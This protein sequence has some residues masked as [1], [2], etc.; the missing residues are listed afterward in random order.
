MSYLYQG[1]AQGLLAV[2]CLLSNNRVIAQIIPDTTL[3]TNSLVTPSGNILRIDQG[4]VLGNNLFHSFQEFSVPTNTEAFFDNATN[5]NNII[6][7][8]TGGNSSQIDG[9]LR[10]NGSANLFFINPNGIVFGPTASLNLGGSFIASTADSLQFADGSSFSA[11]NPQASPLLTMNVPIGLQ[12]GSNPGAVVLQETT[13]EVDPGNTLGLVGGDVRLQGGTLSAPGIDSQTQPGG[14]IELGSVAANQNV[15]LTPTAI[16]WTFGYEEVQDFRDIHLSGGV[17]VDASG[18]PSGNIQVQSRRLE[19]IEGSRIVSFNSG[20]QLGGSIEVNASE[21]VSIRGNGPQTHQENLV[22][23]VIGPPDSAKLRHGFFTLSFGSG[24]AGDITINTD[25][26][27]ARDGAFV[28]TQALGGPAGDV[29]IWATDSIDVSGFF[30]GNTVALGAT[31]PSG[32]MNINTRKLIAREGTQ[33]AV[34]SLGDGRGG[35]LTVNASETIELVGN[36]AIPVGNSAFVTGLYTTTLGSQDAGN[37]EVSTREI[38]LREGGIMG[39][40]TFAG[41]RGGSVNIT[42][43]ESILISGISSPD[44]GFSFPSSLQALAYP[45]STNGGGDVTLTTGVL[46]IRNGANINVGALVPGFAGSLQVTANSVILDNQ[47]SLASATVSG[48]GGNTTLNVRDF[49]LLRN[50]SEITAEAG[51]SGNGGNVAI[52]TNFVVAVEAENSDIIANAFTGDGG[53]INI[54]A[55]GIFGLVQTTGSPNDLISEINASSQTGIQGVVQITTPDVETTSRLVELPEE[56]IDL[57]D[58]VIARCTAAE[59]NSFT[60]TGSGGIPEDPTA[61][62]RGQT[63]WVDLQNF[64]AEGEPS[65]TVSLKT[66]SSWQPNPSS[67]IVEATGWVVDEEGNV[68]LVAHLPDGTLIGSASRYLGCAREPVKQLKIED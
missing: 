37:L 59:G 51:G 2:F 65:R 57:T 4:T 13:L 9:M 28:E 66:P 26:L 31:A 45:G 15:S 6:N 11:T 58:Q 39:A 23:V 61:A 5:I 34:V 22:Q 46:T 48:E 54:R 7:R 18:E 35:N 62:I 36:P 56:V 53:N 19:L 50:N 8:V 42:A 43:T 60:I 1:C 14:R 17:S 52:D 33:I 47:G 10:A 20:A 30:L 25:S 49:I 32:N 29:T 63:V 27:I 38:I 68:E 41:G 21:V 67:P 3:P 44:D 55:Q 12:F 40:N 16:G 24:S 64:S